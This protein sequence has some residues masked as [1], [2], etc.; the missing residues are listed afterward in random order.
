MYYTSPLTLT[1]W[2]VIIGVAFLLMCVRVCSNIRALRAY[3][4]ELID[5][6]KALRIHGML[7]YQGISLS[8]YLHKARPMDVERH[9]L[10]CQCCSTT[11]AC[12]ACLEQGK[13]IDE[14]RF[15]P[16]AQELKTFKRRGK[17]RL[18]DCNSPS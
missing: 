2:G 17:Q 8:R 4:R 5:R 13:D 9:L 14:S 18:S 10:I 16:N 6:A 1:L 11:E 7:G 3:R 12:D 15:C